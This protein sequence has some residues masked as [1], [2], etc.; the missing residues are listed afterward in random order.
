MNPFP[1]D[2]EAHR[3]LDRI[4]EE[5]PS[6]DLASGNS[7]PTDWPGDLA[8]LSDEELLGETVTDRS[9]ALAVR[10]GLLLR[11]DLLDESHTISQKIETTTG[12][13]WHGIIHRREGDFGNSKYWFR[14]VGSHPLFPDLARKASELGGQEVRGVHNA[15]TWDPFLFIDLCETRHTAER[16][17]LKEELLA[18]QELEIDWLLNYSYDR[19]VSG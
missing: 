18:L 19:A 14:H 4:H 2:S 11:A 3:L 7:G 1:E 12:S 16:D 8:R 17:R 5:V 9:M 15:G 13:Y 10:G 6:L